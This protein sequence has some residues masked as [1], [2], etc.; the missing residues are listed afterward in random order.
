MPP[1]LPLGTAANISLSGF[2]LDFSFDDI[3][4]DPVTSVVAACEIDDQTTTSKIFEAHFTKSS[5][6]IR[7]AGLIG[8]EIIALEMTE[9]KATASHRSF[10]AILEDSETQCDQVAAICFR[11]V[12][13]ISHILI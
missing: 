5:P 11:F 10:F 13:N 12:L 7:T 8:R 3:G 1:I 4:F 6:I 2:T 9:A